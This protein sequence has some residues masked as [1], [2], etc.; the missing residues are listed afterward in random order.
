MRRAVVSGLVSVLHGAPRGQAVGCPPLSWSRVLLD[1]AGGGAVQ[2]TWTVPDSRSARASYWP[3]GQ[4]ALATLPRAWVGA[5]QMTDSG[6]GGCLPRSMGD[7]N[8]RG[9]T[10]LG[11]AGCAGPVS[12]AA[13]LTAPPVTPGE[14]GADSQ[15]GLGPQNS[16]C[17]EW[18]SFGCPASLFCLGR[19]RT[20]PQG[21]R[22]SWPPVSGPS[23]ARPV[24]ALL[25]V[26]EAEAPRRLPP[27]LTRGCG[28]GGESCR[29]DL[30]PGTGGAGGCSKPSRCSC[31][32][33]GEG[34]G[35]T[36]AAVCRAPPPAS[37]RGGAE[38][39]LNWD[40]D[41]PVLMAGCP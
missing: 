22:G 3:V 12:P 20:R 21:G 40:G 38:M 33:S 31:A 26:S 14:V 39:S 23:P 13:T 1:P 11:L 25:R 34:S 18:A 37:Q 5:T 27:A 30:R 2:V 28:S 8:C 35:G 16:P 24:A 36:H 4:A 6:G 9:P 32:D 29:T 15:T 19:C 17:G 10:A 41:A 7:P